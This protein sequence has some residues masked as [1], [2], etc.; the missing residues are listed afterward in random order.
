MKFRAIA[1]TAA[2]LLAWSAASHATASNKELEARANEMDARLAAVERANQTLVQLQQQIEALRQELRSLRGQ[3][4]ETRHD[5]GS[6]QQQQRDLYSDLDRR[7]L[8]IENGAGHPAAA[9]TGAP[10]AAGSATP[11]APAQPSAD[12][13][14]ADE[15]TV[16]G[17]SF[18]ALKAGRYEEAAKGFQL[19]LTKY[20]DGPRADSATYWLGEAQYVQRDYTGAIRSFQK[21]VSGFP[22]S[23]KVPD[24]ML[25]VGY[26][27]YELKAFRN[28]RATLQ[29]VAATFPGTEPARL[30][31][32]RL[33]KMDVE[34]R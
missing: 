23:R 11:D 12:I 18:A 2:V 20:P 31:E 1:F 24:A 4:E 29:K 14:A 28:A 34:G 13:V 8:L 6:L 19:Y 17:D 3:I 30:A 7:L 26:C 25:K 27:Q 5:L 9:S 21:V 22:D 32:E 15:S 10:A 33:A 16:Y